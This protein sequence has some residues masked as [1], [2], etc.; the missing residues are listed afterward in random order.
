MHLYETI[1]Q[2]VLYAIEFV[3]KKKA[4][5]I[6]TPLINYYLVLPYGLYNKNPLVNINFKEYT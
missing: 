4:N 5:I 3:L 1:F 2:N 6:L